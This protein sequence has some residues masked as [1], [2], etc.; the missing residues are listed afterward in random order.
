MKTEKSEKKSSVAVVKDGAAVSSEMP[1][2]TRMRPRH[3]ATRTTSVADSIDFSTLILPSSIVGKRDM[4]HLVD[5]VERVDNAL[6]TTLVRARIGKRHHDKITFS[7]QLSDFL[8]KNELS[9]D[10]PKERRM[11]LR[12]LRLLKDKAPVVHVTFASAVDYQSLQR[13]ARW[14]RTSISSQV[15]IEVGLQPGLIAGVYV[16]TPNHIHDLSLRATLKEKKGVLLDD[17]RGLHGKK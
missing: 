10:E 2:H 12:Q 8:E 16:R 1:A 5:E 13:L 11:V 6:T 15:V 14:F 9:L 4:A 17:I 3:R 7:Q